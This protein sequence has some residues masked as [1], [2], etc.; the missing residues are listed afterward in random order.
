VSSF[1]PIALIGAIALAV[2]TVALVALLSL[3]A[4]RH[5]AELEAEM[6][7][8]SFAFRLHLQ[9][10]SGLDAAPGNEPERRST[11]DPRLKWNRTHL[12]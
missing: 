11:T 8:P 6:K 3:R 1:V 7:A 4:L 2:A 12:R 10:R 9:P 5:R